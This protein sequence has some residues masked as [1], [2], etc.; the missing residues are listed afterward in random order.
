[1]PNVDSGVF[2]VHFEY[3]YH[4]IRR[5]YP[6]NIYLSKVNNRT[7]KKAWNMFKINIKDTRTK[8]LASFRCFIVTFEQISRIFLVFPMLTFIT[9]ITQKFP[10]LKFLSS[11]SKNTI[12]K[13]YILTIPY[14]HYY[15]L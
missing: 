10:F 1:M 4:I 3:I 2:I 8:S 5:H 6:V 9:Q 13:F 7:L 12:K 15:N 11:V 14:R